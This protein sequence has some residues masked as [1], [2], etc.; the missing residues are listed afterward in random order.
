MLKGK[1]IHVK[2]S[3]PIGG[4]LP[5]NIQ[6]NDLKD[7][8]DYD[9][10]ITHDNDDIEKINNENILFLI[11]AIITVGIGCRRGI[12]F[13]I[14]EKSVLNALNKENCPILS[15]KAISSID[16][17]ANENG[18]LEFAEKYGLPFNTYSA[19]ELNRLEGDFT[20]SDFVKSVVSVD[21][22][23]ERSAIAESRGELIRRKDAGNGVT[24][25]LAI[26]EPVISWK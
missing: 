3:Y 24:V 17:K 7:L 2:S 16:K 4:K 5:E 19:D 25:A 23:C 8:G 18:I 15:L 13:E 21:N 20:K 10:I 6:I 22:V 26:K 11:P 14:I 12:E 1:T 9:V